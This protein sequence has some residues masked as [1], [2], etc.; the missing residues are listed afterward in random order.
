M[1][2]NL[3]MVIFQHDQVIP[4]MTAYN[5]SVST[6]RQISEALHMSIYR[7]LSLFVALLPGI[8]AC[9]LAVI[10]FSFI[11][12]VVSAFLRFVLVRLKFDEHIARSGPGSEWT[13][14]T[15]PTAL[16]ARI[17]FWALLLMGLLIGISAFD[18]SYAA[19]AALSFNLLPYVTH[20]VS[21]VMILIVGTLLARFLA[22]SVLIG[23]VN[24]QL[25]Y[26]RFLS[27]GV[28]WLVLV[29]TAAMVLEHLE[30]GR[31]IV[32]LAFSILFGG[33]VL[34]LAL[35]VGLGSRQI[36]SRSLESQ[37]ERDRP[38]PPQPETTETISHF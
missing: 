23:A 26:A 27:L 20:F 21:S 14:S 1:I 9:F 36:V 19:Y 3:V 13:P 4:P 31:T 18:A 35:A 34:T 28:K 8:L 29:L 12:V 38:M 30:V 22:R 11:G 25:Q 10:V 5:E 17:A 6:W 7:V 32:E 37:L 16:I 33:I 24:A 15:S 2:L